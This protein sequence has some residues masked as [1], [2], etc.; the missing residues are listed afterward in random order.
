[1]TR[2]LETLLHAVCPA[3]VCDGSQDEPLLQA[4][5]QTEAVAPRSTTPVTAVD[6]AKAKALKVAHCFRR[7]EVQCHLS[8]FVKLY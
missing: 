5:G 2:E 1:M 3:S 8:N 4:R 7:S 6:P